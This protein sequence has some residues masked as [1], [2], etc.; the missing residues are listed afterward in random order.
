[1]SEKRLSRAKSPLWKKTMLQRLRSAGAR[2]ANT[3]APVMRISA[4]PA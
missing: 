1:M 3:R 4:I 2:T